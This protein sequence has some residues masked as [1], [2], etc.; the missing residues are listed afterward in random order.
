MYQ[1]ASVRLFIK[2]YCGWCR[3]ALDWL[4]RHRIR[5]QLHDVIRDDNAYDEMLRLS[6]QTLAPVIEVDGRVLADFGPRD[7]ARFWDA[8][9]PPPQKPT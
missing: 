2:P 8:L 9:T 1:P 7:L 4:D 5:Y 6:G 3:Q